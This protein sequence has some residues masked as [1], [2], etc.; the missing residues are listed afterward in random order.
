MTRITKFLRHRKFAR[1]SSSS[2]EKFDFL[3]IGGGSGGLGAARRA[4]AHGA[5]VAIFENDRLGGTCVNVGCVPKKV[6][7]NTAHVAETLK[8][9]EGYCFTGLGEWKFDMAALKKKRDAYVERLNAIYARNIEKDEVHLVRGTAKFKDANTIISNGKEY[10]APHILIA[11]GGAPSIPDIPGKEYI[12]TSDDFFN[13]L[14]TLPKKAAVVGAGYIAV[15]LGHVLQMLGVNVSLFFRN[16]SLLRT[17]DE[18]LQVGALTELGH[19][20]VTLMGEKTIERIDKDGENSF[21]LTDQTGEKHEGFDYVLYAVG[22]G[23]VTSVL[24]VDDVGIDMDKKG[25]IHSNDFEETNVKGI[26][27]LGDVNGKIELTPVAIRAGRCLADRLFAGK[28]DAKMD[29]VNVPSVVFLDPP[30]GS[31]GMTEEEANKA[32][33]GEKISIYRTRFRNMYYTIPDRNSMTMFKLICVGENE[34]V[35]GMHLH[36]LGSDEML[37][38]FGVAIKMG[39]TKEDIDSVVAIHPTASEEIVT[40]KAPTRTYTAGARPQEI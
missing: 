37:Q 5:K 25:Y 35:V 17:F 3:V 32:Y 22:R 10:T 14:D 9:A 36:G 38:G 26:Y 16:K 40:M 7:F 12:A 6:M 33:V 2:A 18:D 13:K 21:T 1:F 34:K 31:V 39:A 30:I 11:C 29:Y 4:G 20:G 8:D 28:T 27:S 15:E 19:A 23:P 24:N